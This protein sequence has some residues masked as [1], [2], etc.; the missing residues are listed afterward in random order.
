MPYHQVTIVA[1]TYLHKNL[2]E[3]TMQRGSLGAIEQSGVVI[4][5][6]PSSVNL[7]RL[8]RDLALFADLLRKSSRRSH[9]TIAYT[10]LPDIDWNAAWKKHFTALSIGP[11]TILP[12]WEEASKGRIPLIIDPGMAFGTGH[13]ETTRSCLRLME[14]YSSTVSRKRFLDLGTGTGLLALAARKLGFRQVLGID[15]DPV[16][17]EAARKNSS[18]N[19]ESAIILRRGTISSVRGH[20][21]MIVANLIA[22]TLVDIMAPIA[23]RTSLDGIVI[24]AGILRGQ[25]AEISAVANKEGM[26]T[27]AKLR[28]GKWISLVF[29]RIH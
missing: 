10:K 26:K 17:L 21:D 25:D 23:R 12:P 9:I 19:K 16:A 24:A 18:L 5:Y 15:T 8:Q 1:P 7:A 27:L 6:F 22:G 14:R 20:Y 2:L 29:K 13:H 3:L 11:F 28:D 4:A